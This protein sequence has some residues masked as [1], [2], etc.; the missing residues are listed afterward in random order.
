MKISGDV[1][2]L[3]ASF[4]FFTIRHLQS[5]FMTFGTG[6]LKQSMKQRMRLTFHQPRAEPLAVYY[7]RKNQKQVRKN[8]K[9]K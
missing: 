6:M 7:K 9:A 3:E 2:K 8:K 5:F 4:S 1:F